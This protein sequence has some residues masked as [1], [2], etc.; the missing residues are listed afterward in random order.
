MI[1]PTYST[2]PCPRSCISHAC[3]RPINSYIGTS[4]KLFPRTMRGRR[5]SVRP[6]QRVYAN[7]QRFCAESAT[8]HPRRPGPTGRAG[9]VPTVGV[10]VVT[11]MY[12][13]AKRPALGPFVRDQVDALRRREDVDVE[14]FASGPGAAAAGAARA[15]GPA[16]AAGGSTS[17]TRTRAD[18]LAGAARPARPGRR[19]PA[20]QR[21]ARAALVLRHARGA[22][23]H[24]TDRG[25]VAR[26]QREPSG[27]RH[28]ATGR[29][30][31][32]GHRHVGAFARPGRNEARARLGLDPDGPYLLFPHHP[33][34]P[35]KRYDRA[36][37]AAGDVPLL[38]LGGVAPDE[39]PYW[40]NAANA[41]PFLSAEEGFG[42]SV[43][44]ALA[45]G[46]PAFGTPVGIDPVALPRHPRR[47]LRRSGTSTPGAPPSPP[48]L[49]AP[50]PPVY[51][52]ARA[53]LVS[54]D[55]M[56]APRRRRLAR[57][58]RR[59][60]SLIIRGTRRGS[61]ET[62]VNA[63]HKSARPRDP[64]RSDCFTVGGSAPARRVAERLPGR[65]RRHG[66]RGQG[67]QRFADARRGTG[68]SP[69]PAR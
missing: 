61:A 50:D 41:V 31:A 5:V 13:T 9:S 44:E 17:C 33:S 43:I 38:T 36:V 42:L 16:F 52:R 40:I 19:D 15:C 14:L 55:A 8:K 59:P 27:R 67:A 18:R 28:V 62:R 35:L 68:A 49:A 46:V 30:P 23:L 63:W 66:A 29:G 69:A 21:P 6:Q 51:G 60:R 64:T 22:A 3:T 53:L 47:L 65:P 10:L 34:R 12:P 1:R 20:R 56:A 2:V 26:V 7:L 48:H 32:G 54:A 37:A 57:P 4:W 39:V 25:R 11:N 24:G 45:C 58:A